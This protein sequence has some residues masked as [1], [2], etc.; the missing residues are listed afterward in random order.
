MRSDRLFLQD[1]LDA[2]DEVARFLP[3]D[4]SEF[5]AD[6][7]LQSHI[8]RHVQI[9]GE[10]IFRITPETK[11]AHPEIAWRQIAGM[12][13]ILVHDYFRVDWNIVYRTAADDLP[14]LRPRIEA[15]LDGLPPDSP[16]A[17]D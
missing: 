8:L 10:A 4:R 3:A 16:T 12:R 2:I 6:P 15:I 5:D 11:A 1:I 7:L 9:V 17:N 13:H 14:P